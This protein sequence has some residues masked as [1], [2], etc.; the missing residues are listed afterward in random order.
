MIRT[1]RANYEIAMNCTCTT[2]RKVLLPN[3]IQQNKQNNTNLKNVPN[4]NLTFLYSICNDKSVK[5]DL[6][7]TGRSFRSLGEDRRR[8]WFDVQSY[9]LKTLSRLL[10]SCV[11]VNGTVYF[12]KFLF[13]FTPA[14]RQ[15][16]LV[17]PCLMVTSLLRPPFLIPAKRPCIFG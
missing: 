2:V 15:Q 9:V 13:F 10:R 14:S 17:E 7:R 12:A 4:T 8:F 6:H 1:T 11:G 5:I 16:S 3:N